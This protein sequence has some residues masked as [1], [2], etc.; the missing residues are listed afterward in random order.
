[1]TLHFMLISIVLCNLAWVQI[2]KIGTSPYYFLVNRYNAVIILTIEDG[3][4]LIWMHFS[5]LVFCFVYQDKTKL[6]KT[7][8]SI[9]VNKRLNSCL[10]K[11]HAQASCSCLLMLCFAH[12]H[13]CNYVAINYTQASK[14]KQE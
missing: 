6:S 1:M 5:A 9:P 7:G 10:I 3:C 14:A 4:L 13:K 12:A 11:D 2:F 8:L